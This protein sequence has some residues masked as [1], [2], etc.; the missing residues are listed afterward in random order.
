MQADVIL[1]EPLPMG[2]P[3]QPLRG[4]ARVGGGGP[5]R[6]PLHT[7]QLSA[8]TTLSLLQ[9]KQTEKTSLNSK[10]FFLFL[11]LKFEF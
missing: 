2:A 3:P 4:G 7:I 6:T 8:S 5:P 10:L 1:K 11:T 9:S